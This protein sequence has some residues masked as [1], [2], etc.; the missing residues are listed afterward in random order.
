M[1]IGIHLP[2]W[3]PSASRVGVLDVARTA[4]SAGFDS[5]WVADHI[6][7]PSK[8]A[9][10]Y[11]YRSAGLPFTAE[12]GFLEAL[13]TLAVVAGATERI[14][15]GTSVLVLPMREPLLAA[16]TIA[17]LDVL[18]EGRVSIAVGAGWWREEFAAVGA[19]FAGRGERFDEQL[20]LLRRL[21][22]T[23][24]G[25]GEREYRFDEVTCRPLPVQSGGPRLWIGGTGPV[26]LRRAARLGDGWH[27]VG[28][29]IDA[30]VRGRQEVERLAREYG[31]DP[32]T[33]AMS[34]STGLGRSPAHTHERLLALRQAGLD[35]VVVNAGGPDASAST[36]CRE[37][38]VFASKVSPALAPEAAISGSPEGAA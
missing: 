19:P 3:G 36:I 7:Y 26:S 12:D 17:S 1:K 13:T 21:W 32:N 30:L 29:D 23:G 27:A 8:S 31:R 5:V 33:L 22:T 38:E 18:S 35:Q 15:L 6:V 14:G 37:I 11:P 10:T 9:S 2:Q 20:R 28:R 16:K 25:S 24:A 34:T 4:E